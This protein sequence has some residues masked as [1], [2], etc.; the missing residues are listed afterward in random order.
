M[1]PAGLLGASAVDVNETRDGPEPICCF[2][3]NPIDKSIYDRSA[4]F[5]SLIKFDLDYYLETVLVSDP[6][7]YMFIYVLCIPKI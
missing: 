5:P 4:H 3:E 7:Q 6:K 2:H 1:G